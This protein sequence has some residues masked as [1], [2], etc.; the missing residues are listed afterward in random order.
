MKIIRFFVLSVIVG[1]GVNF[2]SPAS[3]ANYVALDLGES[4]NAIGINSRGQ[5]IG[6]IANPA[7]GN[8][9]GRPFIT[10]PDGIG[11]TVLNATSISGIN[12][13]GQVVGWDGGDGAFPF[14][15][16][17]FFTG[18]DGVGKTYLTALAGTSITAMGINNS[19]QVVGTTDTVPGFNNRAFITDAGGIGMRD[20]GTLGGQASGA[21]AVNASGQVVGMSFV[22]GAARHAFITGPNGSGMRDLGTLGG[23]YSEA[24]AVNDSGQVA[25]AS[26]MA[27]GTIRAFVT[28]PDGVAMTNLGTLFGGN[29]SEARD[30]NSSGW[31]VGYSTTLNGPGGTYAFIAG[32]DGAGMMELNAFL[33]L[34]D[35]TITFSDVSAINDLGQIVARASNGRTYLLSPVPEPES[36]ALMVTGFGLIGWV[37]RRK[38]HS[39]TVVSG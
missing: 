14:D 30:I 3:S 25:G 13:A 2:S 32:I 7:L 39:S 34:A 18:P 6:T 24:T 9:F 12:D 16:Q 26:S 1:A 19:G 36:C 38:T 15:T 33:S 29:Y 17:A 37:V 8:Y 4:I 5:V 20:L 27:D 35:E 21:T 10:G 23:N 28:G 22:E 31:V 11:I